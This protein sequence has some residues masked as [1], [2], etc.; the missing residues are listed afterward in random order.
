MS[1]TFDHGWSFWPFTLSYLNATQHSGQVDAAAGH[2]RRVGLPRRRRATRALPLYLCQVQAGAVQEAAGHQGESERS[3][4]HL[5]SCYKCFSYN[6]V[7]MP[8]K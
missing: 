2:H 1:I 5:A 3:L 7:Q 8:R 4:R 6:M